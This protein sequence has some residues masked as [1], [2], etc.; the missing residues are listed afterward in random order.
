MQDRRTT[1]ISMAPHPGDNV[2]K[3]A[4]A[5]VPVMEFETAGGHTVTVYAD[6]T[7]NAM[8]YRPHCT[9]CAR[10]IGN[11]LYTTLPAARDAAKAHAAACRRTVLARFSA[12]N[13]RGSWPAE[14]HAAD[15]R[16]AGIPARVVL[17]Y[18][19]DDF[20][21]VSDAVKQVA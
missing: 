14:N 7:A 6:P 15:L 8:P 2:Q 5:A 12:G 9:G 13:P 19:T 21:V 3:D 17:D 4:P 10:D 11:I 1:T 16:R 18:A 20:L